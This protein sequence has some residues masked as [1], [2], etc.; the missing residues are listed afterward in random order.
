MGDAVTESGKIFEGGVG[1][2]GDLERRVVG[3]AGRRNRLGGTEG[4]EDGARGMP[5]ERADGASIATRLSES[6]H[7]LFASSSSSNLRGNVP[8]SFRAS[9]YFRFS[10]F[11]LL[12][13]PIPSCFVFLPFALYLSLSLFLLLCFSL[14]FLIYLASTCSV[15][16]GLRQIYTLLAWPLSTEVKSSL[17]VLDRLKCDPGTFPAK[18]AAVLFARAI[19]IF[20]EIV[21]FVA[22][23]YFYS[24]VFH[25]CTGGLS[26]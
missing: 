11:S 15:P 16:I 5:R 6:L 22:S 8:L 21:C 14:F 3:L 24:F 10:L 4:C 13:S 20:M 17:S 25:G 7:Y 12:S 2:S 1:S 26:N 19:R 9:F 23:R 18:G